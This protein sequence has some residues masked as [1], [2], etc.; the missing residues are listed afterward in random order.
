M[1]KSPKKQ[2]VK[3][4]EL[5]SNE[6]IGYFDFKGFHVRYNV[7]TE[8]QDDI[9]QENP[10]NFAL[11]P[12]TSGG[13][14][15]SIWIWEGVPQKFKEILLHHELTEADLMLNQRLSKQEAHRV[16]FK[17]HMQYARETMDHEDYGE[18]IRWQDTVKFH[19]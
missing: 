11:T 8:T 7:N 12:N 9:N 6:S 5:N 19:H 13:Q 3:R 2:Q 16:A 18:F 14:T 4:I 15:L 10:A 17:A 1:E